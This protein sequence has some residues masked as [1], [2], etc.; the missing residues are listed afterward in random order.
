MHLRVAVLEENVTDRGSKFTSTTVE[1]GRRLLSIKPLSTTANRV[2]GNALVEKYSDT[3][4]RI[5]RM[6]YVE[7]SKT[8]YRHLPAFLFTS[9]EAP[10]V[11]MGFIPSN[12][13]M[14]DLLR[15]L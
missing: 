13:C 15:N 9:R 6:I 7:Q 12:F 2:M 8:C 3:L 14:I 4:T 10:Q 5:L 11:N 1:E